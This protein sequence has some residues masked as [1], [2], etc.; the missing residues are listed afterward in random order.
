[1]AVES[2]LRR[3]FVG[4]GGKVPGPG[5]HPAALSSIIRAACRPDYTFKVEFE[6]RAE[7]GRKPRV[8]GPRIGPTVRASG[9]GRLGP[10]L[11]P[12]A[13]GLRNTSAHNPKIENMIPLQSGRQPV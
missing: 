10:V 13:P 9:P 11:G 6:V 7:C 4:A 3:T 5:H 8:G 12:S 2:R 1:M